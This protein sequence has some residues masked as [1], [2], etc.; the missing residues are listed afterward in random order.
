MRK[1]LLA[2]ILLPML[3]GVALAQNPNAGRGH[4]TASGPEAWPNA[5]AQ[6]ANNPS[7]YGIL[8]QIQP[9]SAT[10]AQSAPVGVN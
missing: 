9:D 2:A 7:P 5:A 3:G 6:W 8:T 1:I 4:D 10:P